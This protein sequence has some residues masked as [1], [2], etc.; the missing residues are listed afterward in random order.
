MI[1]SDDLDPVT[2][3]NSNGDSVPPNWIAVYDGD[4]DDVLSDEELLAFQ[5]Q[6]VEV[7]IVCSDEE[8]SL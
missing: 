1:A 5:V 2:C 3:F 6:T 4:Y 8:D 7:L